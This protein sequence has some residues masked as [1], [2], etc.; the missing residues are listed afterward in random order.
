ME[1]NLSSSRSA[2][3]QTASLQKLETISKESAL[4][5][6]KTSKRNKKWELFLFEY[7]TTL[8]LMRIIKG[9]ENNKKKELGIST[10][11]RTMKNMFDLL[12]ILSNFTK[13]TGNIDN[14]YDD[15]EINFLLI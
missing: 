4:L 8:E 3:F 11:V 10:F 14:N 12:I 1:N 5:I 9:G 2:C 13:W 7:T 15:H 6:K